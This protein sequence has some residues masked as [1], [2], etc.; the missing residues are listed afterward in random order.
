MEIRIENSA[1]IGIEKVGERFMLIANGTNGNAVV[2][3]EITKKYLKQLQ[4][5]I[6]K[7]LNIQSA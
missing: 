7:M 6:N 2:I 4:K 3:E 5:D 1:W